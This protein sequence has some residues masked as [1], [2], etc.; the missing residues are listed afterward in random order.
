[1]RDQLP[2]RW[3]MRN[4]GAVDMRISPMVRKMNDSNLPLA[5]GTPLLWPVADDISMPIDGPNLP[6]ATFTDRMGATWATAVSSDFHHSPR[7]FNGRNG[8]YTGDMS[9]SSGVNSAIA[10]SDVTIGADF[11]YFIVSRNYAEPNAT[12]VLVNKGSGT[13]EFGCS[14]G[15]TINLRT[16]YNSSVILTSAISYFGQTFVL[17]ARGSASSQ[18]MNVNGVAVSTDPPVTNTSA[19]GPVWLGTAIGGASTFYCCCAIAEF[20]LYGSYLADADRLAVMTYL[21][22]KYGCQTA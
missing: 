9:A 4:L 5:V 13:S 14:W 20:I 16:N 7:I 15:S 19:T 2:D 12:N 18:T 10:S 6:Q 11:T 17:A 3:R 8:W 21:G 1:M 22:R